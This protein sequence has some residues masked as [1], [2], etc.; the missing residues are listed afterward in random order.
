[1]SEQNTCKRCKSTVEDNHRLCEVCRDSDDLMDSSG[2]DDSDPPGPGVS[3]AVSMDTEPGPQV[4][5]AP[6]AEPNHR[7]APSKVAL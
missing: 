1:M 2:D 6:K 5:L 3:G 7:V 4:S